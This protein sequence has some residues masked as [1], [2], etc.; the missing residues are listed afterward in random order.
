[1]QALLSPNSLSPSCQVDSSVSKI[2]A[3][4]LTVASQER[5]EN[6][7]VSKHTPALSKIPARRKNTTGGKSTTGKKRPLTVK[8]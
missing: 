6:T 5:K 2:S 3:L 8:N 4:D 1:M 7:E